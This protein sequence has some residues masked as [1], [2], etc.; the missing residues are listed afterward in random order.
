M[1]DE[2]DAAKV[3]FFPPGVPLLAIAIGYVLDRFVSLNLGWSLATPLRYWVGGILIVGSILLL[4]L[5]SVVLFRRGGQDENPWKPT[6]RIEIRGPYKFTRNPMYLQM[7]L[8]CLGVGIAS[9]NW[10]TILLTPAVGMVLSA[11]AI[12]PEET[13]LQRKF[14]DEYLDYMSRVRRWI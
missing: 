12:R 9:M 5:W 2:K 6:P 3:L 13:Y 4:G 7:V 1:N 14:G 8:V 10:W 11:V